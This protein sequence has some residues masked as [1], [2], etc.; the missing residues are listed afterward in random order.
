MTANVHSLA[1]ART[2]L[3]LHRRSSVERTRA[4]GVRPVFDVRFATE[5]EPM[6]TPESRLV[7]EHAEL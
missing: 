2:H 4:S 3:K 1:G 6:Q 5:A 7:I